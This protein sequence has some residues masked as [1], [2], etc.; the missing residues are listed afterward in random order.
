MLV[1]ENNLLLSFYLKYIYNFH[2]FSQNVFS[3][4]TGSMA[5][6]VLGGIATFCVCVPYQWSPW[7]EELQ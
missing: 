6:C 5:L 4:Y 3:S 7:N 1:I 2:F